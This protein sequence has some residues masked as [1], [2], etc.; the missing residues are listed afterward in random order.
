MSLVQKI[1][2]LAASLFLYQCAHSPSNK[3]EE[4]CVPL[5]QCTAFGNVYQEIK[6]CDYNADGRLD[7]VIT[8]GGF[9][10]SCPSGV[11]NRDNPAPGCVVPNDIWV[12]FQNGYDTMTKK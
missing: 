8:K 7:E 1:T 4:A 10:E 5:H 12:L 6:G 3:S 11:F 2:V 9:K